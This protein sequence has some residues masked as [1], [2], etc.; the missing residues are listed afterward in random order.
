MAETV[1][2]GETKFEEANGKR[3]QPPSPAQPSS[4]VASKAHARTSKKTAAAGKATKS[5]REAKAPPKAAKK[6]ATDE[7]AGTR[8]GGRLV[9]SFPACTF[10]EA[11]ELP[12]GIQ[13]HASGHSIRRLTLFH[14]MGKSAESGTSRQAITNSSRYGLTTGGYQAEHLTLTENGN[15]ATNPDV[16]PAE[17][18]KARFRLA[19]ESI[20]PFKMLYERFTGK[21]PSQSVMRDFLVDNGYTKDEVAEC[22]DTFV[23]NAKYLGLLRE[24][25]GAERL[26]S[27]EHAVEELPKPTSVPDDGEPARAVQIAVAENR[28]ASNEVTDWDKVCFYITPIGEP[29]SDRRLHADLFLNHV[30]EPALE[31]FGL[32]VIRA[33]GIGKPGMITVQ[34][35]QHVIRS[36][37][38]VA[39]LSFHN[40]NVFYELCLRHTCCLPTVQIIRKGDAI[41]FDLKDFNT[42]EIDSSSVYT[43]LPKLETYRSQIANQARRVLGDPGAVD[44][45]IMTFCPG[46]RM[47]I[48]PLQAKG[49]VPTPAGAPGQESGSNG[50]SN[51]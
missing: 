40:P 11:L 18:L 36:K 12:N 29:G 21:L 34:I 3:E 28:P 46:L 14:E 5:K 38:V 47:Q 49:T 26:L 25:A 20:P 23:L 35:I 48:P 45:P 10:E 17:R 42:I 1:N 16:T 33:D 24:I 19:I 22:V 31:E 9:R 8:G 50:H 32:K 39:D 13:K 27:L 7:G 30:V 15:L 2:Q 44:N 51:G 41:P 6:V 4:D 43:L 37:L